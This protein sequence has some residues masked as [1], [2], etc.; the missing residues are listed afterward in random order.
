MVIRKNINFDIDDIVRFNS[1]DGWRVGKIIEM[2]PAKEINY[3]RENYSPMLI[4]ILDKSKIQ[5]LFGSNKNNIY[6]I[7]NSELIKVTD[8]EAMQCYLQYAT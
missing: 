3:N 1:V 4:K 5:I 8:A 7:N 2:Q 6:W